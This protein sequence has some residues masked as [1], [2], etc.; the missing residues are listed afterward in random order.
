MRKGGGGT[1]DASGGIWLLAEGWEEGGS[2]IRGGGGRRRGNGN[3][4][5][6]REDFPRIQRCWMALAG[7]QGTSGRGRRE[8]CQR[9]TA[10]EFQAREE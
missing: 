2:G 3:A 9:E 7:W 4:E 8:E 6:A 10:G 5:A 1:F